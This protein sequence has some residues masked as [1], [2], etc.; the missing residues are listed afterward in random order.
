MAIEISPEEAA[1][2][3][4]PHP[5]DQDAD[6]VN[7]PGL[8]K[9]PMYHTI[10][11]T[12][13]GVADVARPDGTTARLVTRYH[14]VEQVLRNQEAFSRTAAADADDVDLEGTLLGLDL[15]EHASVRNAVKDWF[16]P[17]AVE[18]LR[19]KAEERSAAQLAE[20]LGRGEPADLVS[21]F[22]LPFSLHLVCDML[23]LPQEGRLRFREWGDAFL[24]TTEQT[25]DGA[26]DALISMVVYMSQLVEERSNEPGDDLLS[27]VAVGAAHL[28]EDRQIKLPI[29]LVLGGWE[30][31]ASSIGTQ[32]HVL[33]THPYDGYETAYAYL[34]DHPDAVQGAV[35]EL[36]R[37]FSVT[38]A[39][40]M[41]RRVVQ[42][43]TL[44]SGARLHKGDLVIPSHDAANCDPRVFSDPHRMDFARTPNR[45][46]SFGYGVHHCI[47]RHLGHMEVVMAIALLTRELPT[48]RLAVPSDDI[49]RKPGHAV[50][51]PA[52]LPVAWSASA[53]ATGPDSRGERTRFPE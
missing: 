47:G 24:G 33:L 35:T 7:R 43:V 46:L 29:T 36:E 44:P 26:A 42:D 13:T 9:N 48:L 1:T 15:D 8:H 49:T 2:A 51:G 30:T 14:D 5:L 45:H 31:V 50:L 52:A 34:T 19:V 22:A 40:E 12:G 27:Q 11:E 53:A 10:R 37:L 16:T 38:A 21:D 18:R 6:G 3:P 23:G 41:P 28:S 32:V 4:I 17:R 39:D 25:R 20:M